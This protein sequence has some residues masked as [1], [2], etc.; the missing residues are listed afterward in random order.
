MN[1]IA[2][3]ARFVRFPAELIASVRRILAEGR[4]PVEAVT[5]LRQVGYDTGSAVHE[6]V[7]ERV[8]RNA[9][10]VAPE[11]VHPDQFWTAASE[12]FRDLGW[13]SVRHVTLHPA[14]GALELSDWIEAAPDAGPMPAGC[15]LTTGIFTDLLSRV[16]GADVAVMEIPMEGQRSSRLLFGSHE[17]LGTVYG[18]MQSGLP[19]EQAV[20]RLG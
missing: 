15:H 10:G 16:A 18:H 20:E 9:P 19:V 12:F 13:G 7:R 8:A 5:M 2:D 1:A 3:D 6:G 11:A 14:V 17:A 4:E